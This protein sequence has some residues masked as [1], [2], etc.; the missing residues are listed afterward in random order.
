ME[1]SDP[2]FD[3]EDQA[4]GDSSDHE[5]MPSPVGASDR[6]NQDATPSR[7]PPLLQLPIEIFQLIQLHMDASTFF[8]SLLTCKHFHKTATSTALLVSHLENLPGIRLG[9]EDFNVK[10]LRSLFQR[11]AADS[12]QAAGVLADVCHF[13][14]G[15]RCIMSKST[16]LSR[17]EQIPRSS[18]YVVMA[19]PFRDGTIQLFEVTNRLVR[20]RELLEIHQDD[21]YR[22]EIRFHQLAFAPGSRD[23][24]VLCTLEQYD[25]DKGVYR[26]GHG[27]SW[28]RKRKYITYKLVVFHRLHARQKGWFYSS[29]VQ[30]TRDVVFSRGAKVVDLA[31][32]PTGVACIAWIYQDLADTNWPAREPLVWLVHRNNELMDACP[33]DPCPRLSPV[34][35]TNH[36]MHGLVCGVGFRDE[37]RTLDLFASG[38]AIPC[39][40]ASIQDGDHPVSSVTATQNRADFDR[41]GTKYKFHKGPVFYSKHTSNAHLDGEEEPLCRWSDLTIAIAIH[42]DESLYSTP[43]VFVTLIETYRDP[44]LCDHRVNTG[45]A[46]FIDKVK[47]VALLAG[48]Q[49]SQSS[50]GTVMAASSGGYRIAAAMWNCIYIWCFDAKLLV[51]ADLSTYFPRQDYNA[52]KG[53]GRIRPTLLSSSASVVHSMFWIGDDILFAITDQG[54]SRFDVSPLS[55]GLHEDMSIIWDT[56]T[57]T[58]LSEPAPGSGQDYVPAT[59]QHD[60]LFPS[61]DDDEEEEAEG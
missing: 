46:R 14:G 9:F 31:L 39:G 28:D 16:A 10:D 43:P 61:S 50:L 55:E 18:H 37:G 40:R 19:V 4:D 51:D 47:P 3:Q 60:T 45:R 23:L 48:F 44:S 1:D 53:F 34:I 49:A 26:S 30:D 5:Q 59:I 58:A 25:P 8:I 38:R 29:S 22:G 52:A 54:L 15:T 6:T 35:Y 24:A 42:D 11:R 33:Y 27:P 56:W 32:S 17:N 57:T 12:G 21:D 20:K 7:L 2:V 36:A 41:D 13:D